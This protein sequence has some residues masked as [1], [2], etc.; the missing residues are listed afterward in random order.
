MTQETFRRAGEGERAGVVARYALTNHRPVAAGIYKVLLKLKFRDPIL[1]LLGAHLLLRDKPDQ[2]ALRKTVMGNLRRM[3]GADHPDVQALEL[4]GS[5][6]ASVRR[7]TAPPMLRASWDLLTA[8]SVDTKRRSLIPETEPFNAVQSTIQTSSP[9]LI[10]E[11]TS[12]RGA[13]DD[14]VGDPKLEALRAFVLAHRR[15]APPPSP[16]AAGP[17]GFLNWTG[18]LS[19]IL[20][21][22]TFYAEPARQPPSLDPGAKIALARSL[23]VS[24]ARLDQMLDS[25]EFRALWRFRPVLASSGVV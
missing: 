9:W 4:H 23:G 15:S 6:A 22:R 5:N 18:L 10:W 8:A 12:A 3:L 7:L 17:G 20:P 14:D 11:P 24:G 16:P 2:V 25:L 13:T 1:G 19:S 21:S